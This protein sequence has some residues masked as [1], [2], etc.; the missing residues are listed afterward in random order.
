MALNKNNFLRNLKRDYYNNSSR[1]FL[2]SDYNLGLFNIYDEDLSQEENANDRNSLLNTFNSMMNDTSTTD[3]IFSRELNQETG[4]L[5]RIS[6][7]E[8]DKGLRSVERQ[9]RRS[10]REKERN[11]GS[12]KED[13]LSDTI[14]S[15]VNVATDFITPVDGQIVNDKTMISGGLN[16][17]A[18]GFEFGNQIGGPVVGSIA[19]V[20]G[21]V[22]N[23]FKQSKAKKEYNRKL[24]KE[25]GDM[26]TQAE[27]NRERN[28]S[29]D[30]RSQKLLR[31]KEKQASYYG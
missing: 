20:A 29:N 28:Y 21:G 13:G 17:A 12:G 18:K 24:N 11:D 26:L 23:F 27:I 5:S 8:F 2:N 3:N 31:L 16:S 1:M 15:G 10:E 25:Y 4:D 19:A 7:S 14:M 22:A 9:K 30:I 6:E